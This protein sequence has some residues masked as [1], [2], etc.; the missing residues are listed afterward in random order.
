MPSKFGHGF[1]V[2]CKQPVYDNKAY[3]FNV[4]FDNFNQV[5]TGAAASCSSNFAFRPHSGGFDSTASHNL[6]NCNCTKCDTDSYLYADAPSPSQLGW[7][8]GCGDILCTGRQNYL[9]QDW[10]GSFLGFPGTLIP[11]NS[12][13]GGNEPGCKFSTFMN[14]YTCSR[15]DFG[16]LE[17]QN[18][19]ADFNTRIMWPVNLTY[20]GSNYTTVTNGWRDWEWIGKQP[21][22]KRF[23]RF[24]SIVTL[25]KTYNMTYAA[26]PPT[27]LQVQLRK[28][29]P[30]G[31][32]SKYVV[33]KLHYPKP[34]SISVSVNKVIVKPILLTDYIVGGSVTPGLLQ[35]IDTSLCGSNIY[36]YLTYTT[37]F[38]VTQDA[39]CIVEVTLV[40]TIQLTTHFAMKINDFFSDSSK[41]TN[42]INN[43]CALLHV[44]DTSRVKVVGV[45]SGSTTITTTI[46]APSATST[47]NAT[48]AD[49][50]ATV[51]AVVGSGSFSSTMAS[52]VG[53]VITT[54]YAIHLVNDPE[55]SQ[56][57]H[58]PMNIALIVGVTV[59][60]VVFLVIVSLSILA[61]A[62]KRARVVDEKMFS[63]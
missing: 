13:I 36:N 21:Q 60:S 1:D 19:A 47:D 20:D 35:N 37:T 8:G 9:I 17:Y 55:S 14:A 39:N 43:L 12:V 58:P 53:T 31:D 56:D 50:A 23:G 10:N 18:I 38:V 44:T 24:V 29:T 46:E 61:C 11:N 25:G 15:S 34:N 2:V 26:L 6:F 49:T 40:D 33:I 52:G 32:N 5:Y 27:N 7:F 51:Q 22:N 45:F 4:V 28:R 57:G 42:F 41:M 62:R 54:T 63:S 48:I 30:L 59:A 3:L 16:V